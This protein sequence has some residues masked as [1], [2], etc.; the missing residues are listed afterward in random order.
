V[1]KR[2]VSAAALAVL[3]LPVV[4]DLGEAVD[5]QPLIKTAP[6]NKMKPKIVF[7]I[8]FMEQAFCKFERR[9]ANS[10]FRISIASLQI[11]DIMS[12]YPAGA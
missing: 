8:A 1:L 2:F 7:F 4:A 11:R 10:F 3:A 12:W 6:D 5:L 9:F